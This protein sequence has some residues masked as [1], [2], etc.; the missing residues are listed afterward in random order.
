[1][2]YAPSGI[3]AYLDGNLEWILPPD[4]FNSLSLSTGGMMHFFLDELTGWSPGEYADGRV[5]LIRVHSGALSDAEV[6]ELERYPFGNTPPTPGPVVTMLNGGAGEP[7]GVTVTFQGS[8]TTGGETSATTSDLGPARPEGFQLGTPA[9]YYEIATTATYGGLVEVC[10]NYSGVTFPMGGTPVLLHYDSV[11]GGWE[12]VTTDVDTAM[13]IICGEVRSLSPFL[14][15]ART[16]SD[17]D[18]LLDSDEAARGTDPFN[19]DT[20]G[21]GLL[22]GTEVD[23]A[24]G[25]GCPDPLNADSDGDLL[26]DGAEVGMGTDPCNPDT[27]GD[28]VGDADDPLPTEPGVTSGWLEEAT[29]ALATNTVPGLNL[30][31]FD[32]PNANSRAGRRNALANRAASAANFI[33][34]GDYASAIV[35]LQ[36]L[37]DKIDGVSPPPDWMRPSVEHAE[38]ASEVGLLIS[39]LE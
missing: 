12:D 13:H 30:G 32:A 8:V 20:D 31:L 21:D 34:A 16:D 25:G 38:L 37:L 14:V 1:M 17:G 4:P 10:I 28:G 7:G 23:S 26:L 15:A 39:L 9:T 2:T 11:V 35:E 29:R 22:D 6:A 18:G 5:A 27:D 3:K 24:M 19:P 33:A 36:S